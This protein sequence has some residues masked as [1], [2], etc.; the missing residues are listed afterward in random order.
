[1]IL[2]LNIGGTKTEAA[3]WDQRAEPTLVI[4]KTDAF[5]S[6]DEI[7]SS[8][9]KDVTLDAVMIAIA[10]PVEA[11]V[12]KMTNGPFKTSEAALKDRFNLTYC[13]IVN[14]AVAGAWSLYDPDATS[15]Q[16][17][18]FVTVGTGLG[19]ALLCQGP[20]P[21][22]VP[23]EPGRMGYRAIRETFA[24]VVSESTLASKQ[25]LED[26][27]SGTGLTVIANEIAAQVGADIR[28]EKAVN[29]FEAAQ[30]DHSSPAGLTCNSFW[31]LLAQFCGDM[32]LMLP[33]LASIH[34]SG[35]VILKNLEAFETSSFHQTYASRVAS[36]RDGRK[37][38][39]VL[40]ATD[41]SPEIAGLIKL[42]KTL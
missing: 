28:Y 16:T 14:D 9:S 27:L 35:S 37:G 24:D 34:L 22:V 33:N 6:I 38:A 39:K 36:S 18:L 8:M 4:S 13:T 19:G 7:V 1:M 17:R 31:N 23:F 11:G 40:H 3:L 15:E 30:A 5:S 21:L 25:E 20:T 32:T 2:L 26:V 10:G 29:V 42:H 12:V 41:Q